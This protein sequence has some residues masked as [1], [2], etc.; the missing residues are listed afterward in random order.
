MTRLQFLF[1]LLFCFSLFAM[2]VFSLFGGSVSY[3]GG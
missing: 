1:A 2:L 3:G